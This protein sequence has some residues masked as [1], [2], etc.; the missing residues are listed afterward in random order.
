VARRAVHA[1]VGVSLCLDILPKPSKGVRLYKGITY[2]MQ[3]IKK[4][5]NA[6]SQVRTRVRTPPLK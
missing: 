5:A 3:S 6:P 2:E 4:G 1:R